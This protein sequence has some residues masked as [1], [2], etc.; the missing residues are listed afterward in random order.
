MQNTSEFSD[1]RANINPD[2][3]NK[4]HMHQTP[5]PLSEIYGLHTTYKYIT[6]KLVNY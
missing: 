3:A 5:S 4:G 1:H 6:S 2:M